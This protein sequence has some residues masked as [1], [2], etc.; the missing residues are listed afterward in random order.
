MTEAQKAEA[1]KTIAGLI[2]HISPKLALP[3]A[4]PKLPAGEAEQRGQGSLQD[5]LAQRCTGLCCALLMA[6]AAHEC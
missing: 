1:A 5:Q 4:A 6:A 2:A 3:A